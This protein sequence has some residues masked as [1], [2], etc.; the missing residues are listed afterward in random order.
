[1]TIQDIFLLSTTKVKTRKVRSIMTAITAGVMLSVLCLGT[2]VY[3]GVK[4]SIEQAQ[5]K[6][7]K[8]RYLVSVSQNYF[9]TFQGSSF[10]D[11]APKE[12]NAE[13]HKAESA[14][15]LKRLEDFAGKYFPK[16]TYKDLSFDQ[17]TVSVN[18]YFS[19][20]GTCELGSSN[21]GLF[22]SFNANCPTY[23]AKSSKLLEAY[24]GKNQNLEIGQDGSIPVVMNGDTLV[25]YSKLTFE[26]KESA[27][28]RIK[29]IR[30]VQEKN[31]GKTFSLYARPQAILSSNEQ[32]ADAVAPEVEPPFSK[33][34]VRIVGYVPSKGNL[35][36]LIDTS[37]FVSLDA[38][39]TI[40]LELVEG[41]K[42]AKF[43]QGEANLVSIM[44]K[45]KTNP[46][47]YVELN[48]ES[49]FKAILAAGCVDAAC[50]NADEKEFQVSTFEN[51]KQ[52][53]E[54]TSKQAWKF[55]RW[56]ALF[57]SMLGFLA[58][59]GTTGKIAADSV[60]ESGVFRAVGAKKRQ[61][62]AI[63]LAYCSIIMTFSFTIASILAFLF[64]QFLNSK[65][66][67]GLTAELATLSGNTEKFT[68]FSFFG[69]TW[70]HMGLIFVCAQLVG[71]LGAVGPVRKNLRI[72][73]IKALRDE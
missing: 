36:S 40:P 46:K 58:I 65:F 49:S 35:F 10:N 70:W 68:K 61:I 71:W 62:V 55:L 42:A 26:K 66:S 38:G 50:Y 5:T 32:K 56:V 72:D 12:L 7:F 53:F 22:N 48:D 18:A 4:D 51:L 30:D 23:N 24:L 15:R 54:E 29:K 37:S 67:S 1:M 13:E 25:A 17:Q 14:K 39:I 28:S 69:V 43:T 27:E 33:T 63:Y 44:Q 11:S 59:A 21:V 2:F 45:A 6:R 52:P 47:L 41:E 19:D 64:T 57:F 8:D 31:L 34:L 73:T 60:R 9:A 20:A 16:A 3:S